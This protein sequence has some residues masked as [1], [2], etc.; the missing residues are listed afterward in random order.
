MAT[1]NGYQQP[2]ASQYFMHE[3]F[4]D[5]LDSEGLPI[6][7]GFSADCLTMDLA[8]WERLG[9]RGAYVHFDG[10]SGF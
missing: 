4:Q 2:A 9:G 1:T 8:P 5:F 10:R 6:V 7:T 3:A